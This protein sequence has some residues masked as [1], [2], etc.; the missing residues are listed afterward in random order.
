VGPE[1][2]T[3][4]EGNFRDDFTKATADFK[5]KS[6]AYHNV[7][8]KIGLATGT[9]DISTLINLIKLEEPGTANAVREGE[10]LLYSGSNPLVQQWVNLGNSVKWNSDGKTLFGN[11]DSPQRKQILSQVKDTY[12]RLRDQVISTAGT[13]REIINRYP[14]LD[15]RNV[16]IPPGLGISQDDFFPKAAPDTMNT[17]GAQPQGSNPATPISVPPKSPAGASPIGAGVIPGQEPA[18][19]APKAKFK[20]TDDLLRN[21]LFKGMFPARGAK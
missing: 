13:Y 4:I 20:S 16:L 8:A 21:N 11:A 19:G 5:T 9:G 14:G 7:A 10:A 6:E 2:K 18:S 3:K 12:S 1:Q 15:A 17:G